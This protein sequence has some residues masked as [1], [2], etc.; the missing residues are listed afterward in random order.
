[1]TCDELKKTTDDNKLVLAYF[2]DSTDG[3]EY[4]TFL[5]IANDASVAEKFVFVHSVDKACAEENK[6]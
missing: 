4:S 6:A 2:G 1:M 3:K 5:E